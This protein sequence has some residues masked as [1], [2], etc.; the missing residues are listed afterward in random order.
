MNE[1]EKYLLQ[2]LPELLVP[3]PEGFRE[4]VTISAPQQAS[5]RHNVQTLANNRLLR[6]PADHRE[7]LSQIEVN[8]RVDASQIARLAGVWVRRV[9]QDKVDLGILRND[10]LQIRRIGQH[11]ADI[12]VS[13]TRM[14]LQRLANPRSDLGSLEQIQRLQNQ[15]V[16]QWLVVDAIR[17]GLP[18]NPRQRVHHSLRL[19]L[20]DIQTRAIAHH[21]LEP[22]HCGVCDGLRDL[23]AEGLLEL[24]KRLLR[25]DAR[26]QRRRQRREDLLGHGLDAHDALGLGD[27]ELV[28]PV[29][30][31]DVVF[32]KE[33]V[34]QQHLR[35]VQ[36]TTN[37]VVVVSLDP[38]VPGCLHGGPF[39]SA[40][41]QVCE[42]VGRAQQGQ[43]RDRVLQGWAMGFRCYLLKGILGIVGGSLVRENVMGMVID[44]RVGLDQ[45]S[46]RV[47]GHDEEER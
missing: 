10:R 36:A 19:V 3:Q 24:A 28:V 27:G 33:V 14:Q 17:A 25:L 1:S 45:M 15:P 32:G 41:V 18:E 40:A 13:K 16:I 39:G 42:L 9:K 34:K 4:V 7:H 6:I 46:K 26:R 23:L 35:A 37:Q 47:E 12:R 11:Q 2:R 43:G 38:L 44:K 21:R 22:H 5:R 20:L 31:L 29:E 8:I 30:R